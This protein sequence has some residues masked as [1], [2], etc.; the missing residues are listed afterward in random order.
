MYILLSVSIVFS[1]KF[2]CNKNAKIL[3]FSI[4]YRPNKRITI[5]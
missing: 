2:V 4:S 3:K 5:K 1:R